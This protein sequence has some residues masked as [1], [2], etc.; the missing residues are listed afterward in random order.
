MTEQKPALSPEQIAAEAEIDAFMDELNTR[1]AAMRHGMQPAATK[2]T[3]SYEDKPLFEPIDKRE[4]E[5]WAEHEQRKQQERKR[6]RRPRT[7]KKTGGTCFSFPDLC[8]LPTVPKVLVPFPNIGYL[9]DAVKCS[10]SVMAQNKPIVVETSEIP[11][12]HWDTPGS[13]GGLISGTVEHKINFL[14]YSSKVFVEGKAIVYL[15]VKTAHNKY[16]AIG[17]FDKPAQKKVWVMP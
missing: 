8:F 12:T 17:K 10:V 14:E 15:G 13:A 5:T 1:M 2:K 11:N 16:N 6:K 7:R 9:K 3:G 4:D